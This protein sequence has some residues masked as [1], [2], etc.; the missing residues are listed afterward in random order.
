MQITNDTCEARY[1]ATAGQTDFVF[2]FP[3]YWASHLTVFVGE[4]DGDSVAWTEK[5]VETDWTMEHTD[6]EA[7][8]GKVV[9][10]SGIAKGNKVL[11][12][13]SVSLTQLSDYVDEDRLP[14]EVFQ[15]DINLGI[16]IDQQ[17]ARQL[18]KCFKLADTSELKNL[19]VPEPEAGK[20]LYW[21]SDSELANRSMVDLGALALPLSVEQGGTGAETGDE[22][23]DNLDPDILKADTPDLLQTV[24]GDEAQEHT[25]TDLSELTVARNHVSWTLTADSLFS[26]V[27]LPFDGTYVFHVYPAGH[28]LT[29]A[30][31]YK[32]DGT[33]FDPVSSAGEVRI[34]V[35]QYN[36]RKT[37]I[38]LQNMEA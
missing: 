1:T 28:T 8:T 18:T 22:A 3:V 14:A 37:I 17:H 16:M 2:D 34:V 35:E 11:L 7:K 29:I 23:L 10:G 31:A 20:V 21:V 15:G 9:F 13:R 19:T 36:S 27:S 24:Y 32:T 33:L 25:G 26:D 30:S 5:E 6:D 12:L 38:G 4:P